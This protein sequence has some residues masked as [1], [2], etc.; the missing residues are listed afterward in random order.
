MTPTLG[1]TLSAA[2]LAATLAWCSACG[3]ETQRAS[4]RASGDSGE[5]SS[6]ARVVGGE[7]VTWNEQAADISGYKFVVYVD[8]GASQELPDAACTP[9]SPG[10]FSCSATLP[11]LPAGSH[12]LELEGR[13][14]KDGKT[15][16]GRRSQPI[17]VVVQ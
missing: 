12:A 2:M 3:R 9:A 7:R 1:K 14:V 5:P 16:V 8:S 17:S 4:E 15:I 13:I 11:H 10:Q 6:P